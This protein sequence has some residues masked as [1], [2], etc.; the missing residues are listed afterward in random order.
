MFYEHAPES[1]QSDSLSDSDSDD[2]YGERKR[3][4]VHYVYD[5]AAERTQQ[6]IKEGLLAVAALER[7]H[8]FESFPF[9]SYFSFTFLTLL[10][11]I[12]LL[13]SYCY[14]LLISYVLPLTFL[15]I[16]S[17][18]YNSDIP[19]FS[20]FYIFSS[21]SHAIC[22]GFVV[23]FFFLESS[24]RSCFRLWIRL[25]MACVLCKWIICCTFG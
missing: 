16:H 2:A 21:P 14:I 24:F 15:Y 3:A 19:Y 12:T 25:Q 4:Q 13:L 11:V 10:T 17:T 7:V 18:P 22:H 20:M 23:H 6:R 5:A 1:R 8:W 9:R